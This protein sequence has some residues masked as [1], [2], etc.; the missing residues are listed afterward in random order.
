MIAL[1]LILNF[2]S[3]FENNSQLKTSEKQKNLGTSSFNRPRIIFNYNL[4]IFNFNY[5]QIMII[6]VKITSNCNLSVNRISI[7]EMISFFPK[8]KRAILHFESS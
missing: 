5:C 2:V 6:I 4:I 1:N 8:L 7:N 3:K